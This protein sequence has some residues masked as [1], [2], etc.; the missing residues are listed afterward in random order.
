[1]SSAEVSTS[2]VLFKRGTG[3]AWR[4]I[5]ARG[6]VP[7]AA[8]ASAEEAARLAR[9]PPRRFLG[10]RPA[11]AYRSCQLLDQAPGHR[12]G[13]SLR[14]GCLAE[15]AQAGQGLALHP[16]RAEGADHLPGQCG[17]LGRVAV[18]EIQDRQLEGEQG[19]VVD[20]ADRR[21]V[22]PCLL[23][24]GPRVAAP[25]LADRDTGRQPDDADQVEAA[26]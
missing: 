10:S 15:Q 14:P 11:P 16:Q 24:P 5:G 4:R 22:A 2:A 7:G 8:R 12:S 1:M 21:E 20:V 18:L 25:P 17:D 26:T 19:H 9:G 3:Y 6:L 13:R 23:E